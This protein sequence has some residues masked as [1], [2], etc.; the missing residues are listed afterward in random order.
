MSALTASAVDASSL[1]LSMQLLDRAAT[2]CSLLPPSM[3]AARHLAEVELERGRENVDA[4][5]PLHR[6]AVF[7][8][9]GAGKST[10]VNCVGARGLRVLPDQ[11][12][13]TSR[14]MVLSEFG[15][16]NRAE[17][18]YAIT[19]QLLSREEWFAVK[20]R[21]VINIAEDV[22]DDDELDEADGTDDAEDNT[23][24]PASQLFERW[25]QSPRA[26]S[27]VLKA[28]FLDLNHVSNYGLSSL[29]RASLLEKVQLMERWHCRA[30]ERQAL[31][32]KLARALQS[33]LP[34]KVEEGASASASSSSDA[35]TD[36]QQ[37]M[38]PESSASAQQFAVQLKALCEDKEE[39]HPCL[40]QWLRYSEEQQGSVFLSCHGDAHQNV[41][42]LERLSID[43]MSAAQLAEISKGS[44]QHTNMC[45]VFPQIEKLFPPLTSAAPDRCGHM[46]DPWPLL[47]LITVE[48]SSASA[49]IGSR[50]P[51]NVRLM[52]SRGLGVLTGSTKL[53][54]NRLTPPAAEAWI[55]MPPSF[56]ENNVDVKIVDRMLRTSFKEFGINKTRVVVTMQ[57]KESTDTLPTLNDCINRELVTAA[58]GGFPLPSTPV[59]ISK[60]CAGL[61]RL[62]THPTFVAA[63]GEQEKQQYE[64]IEKTCEIRKVTTDGIDALLQTVY[65]AHATR[66]ELAMSHA[67]RA[68]QSALRLIADMCNVAMNVTS[69]SAHDNIAALECHSQLQGT[70]A[71][72]RSVASQQVATLCHQFQ[73]ELSVF[74][75][76]IS[77]SIR[78]ES[79][80]ELQLH[81]PRPQTLLAW[82]KRRNGIFSSRSMASLQGEG[83]ELSL[84]GA[85]LHCGYILVDMQKQWKDMF[86]KVIAQLKLSRDS[87]TISMQG[88]CSADS[89]SSGQR[90]ALFCKSV[91][92]RLQ[93]LMSA[94]DERQTQFESYIGDFRDRGTHDALEEGIQEDIDGNRDGVSTGWMT[95]SKK[96]YCKPVVKSRCIAI[97]NFFTTG[98]YGSMF[99]EKLKHLVSTHCLLM[100]DC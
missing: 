77:D 17:N 52:D 51:Y 89:A 86:T 20:D 35:M 67:T 79:L 72:A 62:R 2:F 81:H 28:V 40:E 93:L 59:P 92:S 23:K 90:A 25:L 31:R 56:R 1:P 61:Y 42:A 30:L 50:L 94:L 78:N 70:L 11:P 83:S 32:E 10:L 82:T 85:M 36:V 97:N 88:A 57:D 73:S 13:D 37:A 22:L 8:C 74:N 71:N 29:S 99:Q 87:I 80:N 16:H 9:K 12:G 27:D 54:F 100:Y 96:S 49:A 41:H 34:M 26:E 55:A 53:L 84:A 48:A 46:V 33:K 4:A 3:A 44:Y 15:V 38:D 18:E 6:I 98:A 43:H 68:I 58:K 14:S 5:L 65:D 95:L 76:S 21:L 63:C 75:T 66:E 64:V 45:K 7:G 91:Q 19:M 24:T 39:H 60:V 47:S 69:W